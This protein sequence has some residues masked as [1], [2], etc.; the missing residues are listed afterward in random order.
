MDLSKETDPE[1][2]VK[3]MDIKEFRER[4]YLQEVNRGFFHPLGMSL[5]IEI[6]EDGTETLKGLWDYRD[7]PE[8]I[9]YTDETLN[10]QESVKKRKNILKE[11]SEKAMY[12]EKH[13]KFIFQPVLLREYEEGGA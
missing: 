1:K 4:G 5:V 11:L 3:W 6:N 9:I 13:L 10:T 2:N 8:G 12:R 7:D